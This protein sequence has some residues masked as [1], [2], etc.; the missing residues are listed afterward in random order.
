MSG[1]SDLDWVLDLSEERYGK[2]AAI[3]EAALGQRMPQMEV[4]FQDLA[5]T[6]DVMVNAKNTQEIPTV[7]TSVR[8]MFSFQKKRVVH[9][10]VLKPMTGAF[11]PG[12]ITLV[13]GQPS[14]GKSSLMKILSGRFPVAK[15]VH[16]DGKITYNG[17]PR[18]ELLSVLPQIVGYCGQRDMHYPTLTVEET[19]NFA[20]ACCGAKTLPREMI[21][22]FHKGTTEDNE[23]AKEAVQFFI[24][25]YPKFTLK[26]LGLSHVANTIVGDQMLRGVSGGERKRVTTGE[27]KFGM[28]LVDLMDE[29]STGLDSAATYDIVKASR[30]LAHKLSKTV[31]ISLLQPPPEVFE[32]FD[33]VLVL[34]D[35]HVMYH[36]PREKVL[37]YFEGLG[38]S[39]PP[40]RDVADFLLDLGTDQQRV[41]QTQPTKTVPR[42]AVDYARCFQGSTYYK[43]MVAYVNGPTNGNF[44][45]PAFPKFRQSLCASTGT[46][47]KRQLTLMVRNTAF[48]KGRFMMVLIMGVLYG[49]T[50][51]QMD[52]AIAQVVVGM[53]FSS[54]MFVAIGQASQVN[55][56]FA[57]RAIFYKQR[58]ANFYRTASY[59]LSTSLAQVPFAVG[60]SIVFGSLVYWLT[61]FVAETSNFIIFL[62]ALVLAN[63]SFASWFFFISS[64]APNLLMAQPL[65]FLSI[66]FF[67]LFAGF[68]VVRE[69]I[70]D[71][72]VWL[73]WI[74]PLA[75]CFRLLSINQ[76]THSSFQTCTYNNVDYC[77]ATGKT[78]GAYQLSLYGFEDKKEWIVYGF[79]YMLGAFFCFLLLSTLFLEFKRY[80]SPEGTNVVHEEEEATEMDE[81][82]SYKELTDSPRRESELRSVAH[83]EHVEIAP[84]R[85]TPVTLTFQDVWYSV[86]DPKTGEDK[87]LLHGVSGYAR[88]GTITA[89]MGSSGA[90]KTTLM[91]VIAGRKTGGTIQG[92]ISLNGFPA[93][94]LSISRVTGYCEQ[95]DQHCE[96]AT[97]REAIEFSAF[98]RQS[99]DISDE[100]KMASVEECLTLL[101][102]HSL[103]NTII[104]GASVE[105][106]KRL[107]IGVELASNASILF[108]DEPTSGLDARAALR[109][110]KGLTQIAKSGRT[111]VCTIHQPSSEVFE[112]FDQLLLLKRGGHTVYFGPLGTGSE[113]LIEYL[114]AVPGTHPIKPGHNPATWM[115]ECIGAGTAV[116]ST[117]PMDF[118][119][120][121]EESIVKQSLL[122][123]LEE[124]YSLVR[125]EL[126]FKRK[127]AALPH[128]QLAFVMK[129]FWRL[130]WRTPSYTLSRVQ[131]NIFL[132]LLFG[133]VFLN[134]SYTT[135]NGLNGGVGIVFLATLFI[136][137]MGFNG[138]LPLFVAE[139]DSYYRERACQTY[140]AVWYWVGSTV[141]EVP[142]VLVSVA[143]FVAI[144]YPFVGFTGAVQG[145]WFTFY[146]FLYVLMQVYF[147]Q[148][149]ACALPSIEVASIIGGLL[150]SIFFLFMGFNPPTSQIPSALRWLNTITPP[151]YGLALLV[152][153]VFAKCDSPGDSD[154]G[155]QT[156]QGIPP[157]F[158]QEQFAGHVGPVT[159][160]DYIETMYG[161]YYD[162]R[163]INMAVL[164][165]CIV[166][167]RILGLLA[168]RFLVKKCLA[169]S[170]TTGE[171]KYRL[172]LID[173]MDQISAGLGPS[174]PCACL[175]TA[176][177]FHRCHM[178][179][180]I[181]TLQPRPPESFYKFDD[182][183]TISDRHDLD[184]LHHHGSPET[185]HKVLGIIQ[186]ALGQRLPQMEIRFENLSITADMVV[187]EKQT[188]EI[189]TVWTSL[190]SMVTSRKSHTVHKEILKP[191]TGAFRPGSM[192]LVLGQPSSGKS[193]LMKVLSGRFPA[194]SNVKIQGDITYNGLKREEMLDVLPQAVSYMSQRDVHYP[195]LTVAET[196]QFA[197]ECS[198]AKTMPQTMSKLLQKGSPEDNALASKVI[199]HYA[200]HSPA[201]ILK[202]LGLTHCADTIVGDQLLRGV[203]GGER[204]RVTTG[205]MKFG[206]KLVDLMDEISTGLDSAATF[207][208]VQASQRLAHTFR[209]TIVI[210][211]LQ[212]PPEVLDLFDDVLVLNDGYVMYHGPRTQVLPYFASLGFTCPPR[213][214]V[215]D[216]LLD[217]GTPQQTQYTIDAAASVPRSAADF[218]ACFKASQ[219]QRN[220]EAHIAGPVDLNH[221]QA[222][223]PR[224]RQSL[225]DGSITVMKRQLK[226]MIRNTAFIQGRISMVVIMGLLYG[227]IFYG[228]DVSLAQVVYGM[229]FSA[230]MFI[231]IGQAA[232]VPTFF[233]SRA[234]FYKQRGAHFYRTA[235][236]VLSTC[237]AQIPFAIGESLVFGSVVYW[238]TGF[239]ADAG[240]FIVFL[241]ALVLAN[242]T[243]ATWFFFISSAAP[244]LLMAQPLTFLSILLYVLFAGFMIAKDSIPD[245]C[246]WIFW[247]NPL[248]W[249]FRALAINQYSNAEFQV[250][251]YKGVEYCE[252]T[253]MNMGTYQ[254]ALYGF[255]ADRIWIVYGFIYMAAAYVVF[256]GL[257]FVFLEYKRYESP[258]G[259]SITIEE[260]TAA[261]GS[262][263]Y[264]SMPNTP[265]G[266]TDGSVTV[267]IAPPRVTPVTLTFQD[268]WYT[269]KEK[270]GADKPLLRNVSG[271]ARPGMITAL[272]GSSGAGKTTLMD[273]LA[274]RK[275]GGTIQ[276]RIMINGYPAT[277][278]A[279]SRVTGYCEQTDQHCESATFREALEFSAF[280]RQSSDVSDEDKMASVEECLTLLDMHSLANTIIRGASVEQMKRLTIG[281]ELASNASILFLDEPTSG[282]DARAALRIMK[283]LTQIAKSGRTIVCTIH[284]PSSEVF[285]M[286]DQ[287]LLLK[288]GGETVYFGPLGKG[289]QHLIDYMG[290]IPGTP[291]INPGYNPAT[292]MLEVIGAGTAVV[293]S[294]TDFAQVFEES[295]AKRTLLTVLEDETATLQEEMVF[296]RKRAALPAVQ[297]RYVLQRFARMYWRTPSYT[298]TQSLVNIG[299]AV[300]FGVIY[301][302]TKY[303]T[304]SGLNAGVGIVFMASLFIGMMGFNNVLPLFVEERASFYR[305][306]ACQTYNALW[307]WLGST[308]VEIPYVFVGAA[309]FTVIFYPFAGF[310]GV[311]Q[312]IW[313]CIY[314]FLFVLMQVYFGQLLACALPS[315]EVASVIGGLISSI[316]FLFMGFNPPTSAIPSGLRWLNTIVPPK[317][318]LALLISTTFGKCD[319]PGDNDLGCR[320]MEGIPESVL[321]SSFKNATSVTMKEYVEVMFQMKDSDNTRNAFVLI[322][323]IAVFRL[324]GLL[325]MR[326]SPSLECLTDLTAPGMETKVLE[327]VQSALGQ[328]LPQMEIRF[329][330]LSI[331]ADFKVSPKQTSEI[332]TVWSTFKNM[333]LSKIMHNKQVVHKEILKPM[334][335]AFRPGTM[336]LVLGQPSSGKS[337]LMK[338]LSGRFPVSSNVKIQGDITYNG[339]KRLDMLD[340]LPQAISYMGQRDVHYPT[341]TVEETL[342][343]ANECSGANPQPK[344][345]ETESSV[346]TAE[347]NELATK[348]VQNFFD[349]YPVNIMK[350][351][352]LLHCAKTVVGDEMLRGVSG[353]E[354]KRVTTGEMKFGMK[355]VDL[356]DEISTG[357]DSAATLDIVK[358]SQRLAHV[359]R[360]TVVIS[361][362]QP[363]PEVL[364]QFDDILVLNEG[365]VMYHGPRE[366]VLEYFESLGFVCPVRRDVADYLLDLG[367]D[368]MRLFVRCTYGASTRTDQQA[369]YVTD[370][371]AKVPRSAS[372]FAARF[373]ASEIYA[374][375]VARNAGPIDGNHFQVALP[376][377]RQ[378]FWASTLTVM[379]RQ[380]KLMLR[381]TAFI[382]G[383]IIMV[384]VMGLLYGF[385]FY[386]MDVS[387]AQV[388]MGMI[389]SSIMFIAIGQAA[390]VNTFYASRAIFYKQ[391]GAHFYRTA[392]Y[393]LSTSLAQIPFAIGE[394]VIFGSLVYW[395]TGF[396]ADAGAF[397]VFICTLVLAN[398]TFASWFFFISSAAPDLLIAQPVTFIS[399]LFYI[400]FAGF[401]ISKEAMPDY[402]VWLLW[403]N[404]LAWCFRL[405]AV[406]QYTASEFQDCKYGGV[407]Y[408][409]MSGRTMGAYQLSLYGF[410]DDR[411]YI[412][413]GFIYMIV[414]Y[415]GFLCLC[416]FFL[417]YKRYESPEGSS[418]VHVEQNA[419]DAEH[420]VGTSVK[421]VPI[422]ATVVTP[423]PPKSHTHG[424]PL[425]LAFS[426]V[427]YSVP[428]K[429]GQEKHLLQGISGYAR[430]LTALMG[431][432]GA[433]KTTLMDVLAGR[434]TG[435]TFKAGLPSTATKLAISRATGYCEQTDQHCESATFREAIEFSAFLRQS[436]DVT[437][438]DKMASVE[439]CL[440]LLD[441]HSLANTIIR[442]ASV[443]QMKRLT[444]GVELASNASILFL[445]EPTSGLD[446]RAALRIMKG[447]T[448]VANTGR[449]VVCTIHQPSTEVFCMFS[450]LLLLKRGGHTVYF[451]PLGPNSQTLIDYLEK[452]PGTRPIEPGHNPA[453]W[454]LEVIGAG[455]SA[456]ATAEP[457]DF[458]KIFNESSA[459][460]AMVAV[461]QE[462]SAMTRKE[463]I[464]TR[465][466]AADPS[467]QMRFVLQRFI[468]MYWR[469]PSYNL[470]RMLTNVAL[471]ILFGI[472]YVKSNYATFSGLNGGVGVIFLGSLFIGMMGFNS[473]LP[474]FVQERASFYRE[475]ACETYS[476]VWYWLASTVVEIPYVFV[477][478]L[479]F[480]VIFY[481]FVGFVGVGQCVLFTIYLFLFVLMQVYFG[482]LLA[483]A[484][485]SIEVASTVGGLLNSIF[486]LFMG[487]NPPTS[488][489][490]T[491]LKWL[492]TIVPPKYS[493]AILVSSVFCKCDNPGD[494]DLGCRV[495]SQVPL[496]L[497]VYRFNNSR[498]VTIKQYIET[499][500][501]MQYSDNDKNV[502]V[503]CGCIVLF[504]LLGYLAMRYVNHQNR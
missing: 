445:D 296:K 374:S 156:L 347:N 375:M 46:V 500:F 396:V 415:I 86:Q 284:Q 362:L 457:Q 193:S 177:A 360:K 42:T 328:R 410:T 237:L 176:N 210:S 367:Y 39:C 198:G 398:L 343:F 239:V 41:Y 200:E 188:S 402:C 232:Q 8:G 249:C 472:I 164:L 432:S 7:W 440:T 502:A 413:Y 495:M 309:I 27:M 378:T 127:R 186:A 212:P 99:S 313:F 11:R 83:T 166:V 196:L 384:F 223:F 503:L 474:L 66:L 197:H 183:L 220:L 492:N 421:V 418:V 37:E 175:R 203:S 96:S 437:D 265:G 318:A 64:A 236:Y 341:L 211:L 227:A 307:Y 266:S 147:G 215:A 484:L 88:P 13:L 231:A 119:K 15:N 481:P 441:M 483:C 390:Q 286:F 299:M 65:T 282:L 173:F 125:Q 498:S 206:M 372:D 146:L 90:G 325:A 3:I 339:R 430:T 346:G 213:R 55:T 342:Q 98:L 149:L 113:H 61:G 60:E 405:L 336:T 316:F 23:Q 306:R 109:I 446:A 358:A 189:P 145:I 150:N 436:S 469:T 118:A 380:L 280:L 171:I 71:Y 476:A 128:V 458:A 376:R 105:Q 20:H 369:A 364:E 69:N 205:E 429:G 419:V 161:M 137:I 268:V 76:Y 25:N 106:M 240:A 499:M 2:M 14:S 363:S 334:T 258:E 181:T 352:G 329:Q 397:I 295:E 214:D 68:L 310:V 52:V 435:G 448:E 54:I 216:F 108:L 438:E 9:K 475:R 399:I 29:I 477:S 267:P 355:L 131:V 246:I 382:K 100:D 321:Q 204:K 395:M 195:I 84:P 144:F 466:C 314:L 425:T 104:R 130:Y 256:M 248:T 30:T 87:H 62:C 132:S 288:R 238:M 379:R 497:I 185:E 439:E 442:G 101:D 275:T 434:K 289:S 444:I 190:K 354:R 449:T 19:M 17:R 202:A 270:D 187:N 138:V 70:P 287:L 409:L 331:T 221:F 259:S 32:L 485:P 126:V 431:S 470:F 89:L 124:E 201:M 255:S 504:R 488:Q 252:R 44:L 1:V 326:Y 324:L 303:T 243:F 468:R 57:S 285:S 257:A 297:M 148:M 311:V 18:A 217:L 250:C 79:M 406:N 143:V 357:L 323:C 480:T 381:N 332:P 450:H 85:V 420:S 423:A 473:V 241:C 277:K 327:V 230:I 411:N 225:W 178:A 467:V 394:A 392:S 471:S 315:I 59:V 496:S 208:I 140:N 26:V 345:S 114:E 123:I 344:L 348:L 308:L 278:L 291:A 443:E 33:D 393:V 494:D 426:D 121:Y 192:T 35:G 300:L 482:Q 391:R 333:I 281:V 388:V 366:K 245:Y 403:I 136:G 67:V 361:L 6:A 199:Q 247:I 159:L 81:E 417:E 301:M 368:T 142:Y 38:F 330:D 351:L 501:Q 353:G 298:L 294:S 122:S 486:F 82:A 464:F 263:Y 302:N 253:G 102:M 455:T 141:V 264:K 489:I 404:P 229:I 31:V 456:G 224:F 209:K 478:V 77:K 433:G 111:V 56:F 5:I 170:L 28:K 133:L 373:K 269:V 279:I 182:I 463:M 276:G 172:W 95:T 163:W 34:N 447:L 459:K 91:D 293:E 153:S 218:S 365:Y 262:S 154:L 260:E 191:M 53:I 320:V 110:M 47:V 16:V 58:G 50:F 319:N 305:E 155:C 234:I 74:N 97:F 349:N 157:S 48:L 491:A 179:F 407:N 194:S 4:R 135:F 371:A 45:E 93:T 80:E 453:T 160:K 168:M 370:A 24:A 152:T 290:A 412:V 401:L 167:F 428:D 283:G 271:Y 78:M 414:A 92:R 490:P 422:Q 350:A 244:N 400:L 219:L 112:M 40:R 359:F 226:L 162:D 129:R 49:F 377:Y 222:E 356:M 235:S 36:G 116:A 63:L 462:E 139:R 408:C 115:L 337:S 117:Q 10:E 180:V 460:T 233:A 274:G 452:I 12:T 416:Y 169:V 427:W 385:T 451:G 184:W 386:Q 272:M 461:L 487:F 317:Y 120:V 312:G 51:Y 304:F 73:Y 75:W 174:A 338:V 151:K 242:M 43:D 479:L 454:M 228:M 251:T 254:L 165:G 383:R 335:G 94:K 207:D 322:G 158:M 21:K 22:S 493:L 273:V 292:W 340:V 389:F 387:L 424:T 72:L 107:T 134:S 465:K 261:E 103:A